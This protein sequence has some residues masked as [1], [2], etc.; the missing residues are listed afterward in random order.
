MTVREAK[1][2]LNN[3]RIMYC[4][5]F[6]LRPYESDVRDDV[7]LAAIRMIRFIYTGRSGKE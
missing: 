2:I 7:R 3:N 6:D 5:I 1:K 4:N